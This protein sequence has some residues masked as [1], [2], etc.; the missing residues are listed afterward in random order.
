MVVVV[1]VFS[2]SRS[3]SRS[4]GGG[5]QR[6]RATRPLGAKRVT[7][8]ASLRLAHARFRHF[9]PAALLYA[10][11]P[12]PVARGLRAK[13][14]AKQGREGQEEGAQRHDERFFSF[15]RFIFLYLDSLSDL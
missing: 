11:R 13:A 14:R 6:S 5:K 12:T 2:F 8:T 3:R 15:P 1:L 4:G 10:Q 7:I 9:S